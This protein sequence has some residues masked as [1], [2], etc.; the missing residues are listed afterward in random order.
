MELLET[1]KIRLYIEDQIV[2]SPAR[3]ARMVIDFLTDENILKFP[4]IR[5]EFEDLRVFSI[6]RDWELA[7]LEEKDHINI[8][9]G[10]LKQWAAIQTSE[11]LTHV[12]LELDFIFIDPIFEK[13]RMNLGYTGY[14]KFAASEELE[15][16]ITL[17]L[18]L[19][20]E[21]GKSLKLSLTTKSGK[22]ETTKTMNIPSSNVMEKD[23]KRRY[24]FLVS[25]DIFTDTSTN[26]KH[27]EMFKIS[28]KVV[29]ERKYFLITIIGLG[30]LFVAFLR[31]GKLIIGGL[32]F[33]IRYLAALVA[34]I[35]LYITILREQYEIPFKRL[36]FF[37][38]LFLA[39]EIVLELLLLK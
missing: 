39:V 19:K 8:N 29:N 11:G 2:P 38:A 22:K 14:L 9:L 15:L 23:R 34:F 37:A 5:G 16:H 17:P 36:I 26:E 24:D 13:S 28:Y 7:F 18:G 27:D 33:D 21:N 31:L 4:L 32:N 20:M 10:D 35:G 30:L 1:K 3:K 12:K 6:N 25:K